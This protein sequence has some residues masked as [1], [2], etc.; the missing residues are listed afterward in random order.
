M[1]LVANNPSFPLAAVARPHALDPQALIVTRTGDAG[2]DGVHAH[3]VH[4]PPPPPTI[5]SATLPPGGLLVSYIMHR[6]AHP[7]WAD[8]AA[9]TNVWAGGFNTLVLLTSSLS[10]VLAHKAAEERLRPSSVALCS[11]TTGVERSSSPA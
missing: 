5:T 6:L 11:C 2:E 7:A 4:L 8:Q 3:I 9:H 10:A 1:T